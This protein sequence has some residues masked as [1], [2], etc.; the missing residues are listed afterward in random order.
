MKKNVIL[1]QLDRPLGVLRLSLTARC[2]LACTYCLPDSIEPP[3]LLSTNNRVAIITAAVKLGVRSLKLTG[4]EPLL[5][6]ELEA[7]IRAVKPLRQN[8]LEEITLTTNGVLLTADRARG[9]KAAGLDRISISLDGTTGAAVAKMAGL[10]DEN[11]GKQTLEKVFAAI[12][13][14]Q[15]SGFDSSNGALKLNAVIKRNA[16]NDQLLPLAQLA[17]TLGVEL[18]LI[19]FMDV[20]NRNQWS[21]AAVVPA[22]EMLAEIKREWPLETLGRNRHNTASRWRYLDGGGSLAIVASISSPFCGDC[23]RLRITADGI[24]Y[25]CLF[26]TQQDGLDLKLL[27]QNSCD[28]AAIEN[29]IKIFWLNR[30]DRYSEERHLNTAT[31]TER[32]EMAYLGG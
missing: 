29:A 12:D 6:P 8:G 22:A 10:K 21:S 28:A 14:A 32:A 24:A 4:G 18:R 26:A 1:D 3:G 20:G 15:A 7:L 13:N 23:N 5:N 9:L 19:E 27:L 2:N 17:R 31:N 30:R 11:A 16:N 25:K